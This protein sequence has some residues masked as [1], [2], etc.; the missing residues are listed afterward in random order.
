MRPYLSLLGILLFSLTAEAGENHSFRSTPSP[1][2]LRA[3]RTGS[4][5]GYL[6]KGRSSYQKPGWSRSR[7]KG[8]SALPRSKKAFSGRNVGH[9]TRSI[10]NRW[11]GH[12]TSKRSGIASSRTSNRLP[13]ALPPRSSNTHTV[14]TRRSQRF[15][16]PQVRKDLTRSA[17]TIRN[18]HLATVM[19][20]DRL[21]S[22][23]RLWPS[24]LAKLGSS[25]MGQAA[26]G[27]RFGIRSGRSD[28]V[29]GAGAGQFST[30]K[31]QSRHPVWSPE[32]TA[33]VQKRLASVQ[34]NGLEILPGRLQDLAPSLQ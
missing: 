3:H 20:R 28:R 9:L 5:A 18:R 1:G 10:K 16:T 4:H 17:M 2:Q 8:Q 11:K 29:K 27:A 15:V 14:V 21:H 12:T 6:H 26:K 30:F 22:Q 33:R 23:R 31:R 24:Q 19:K 25:L 32:M 13:T 7:L 34:R